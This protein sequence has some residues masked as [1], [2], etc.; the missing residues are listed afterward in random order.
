MHLRSLAMIL[1]TW[2]CGRAPHTAH[3]TLAPVQPLPPRSSWDSVLAV[4]LQHV[5]T[6]GLPDYR[7]QRQILIQSDSAFIS[8]SALPQI[9]SIDFVLLDNVQ[10]QRAANELGDLNVLTVARFNLG[11]DTAMVSAVSRWVWQQRPGRLGPMAS[12][13]ACEF[14]LRRLGGAWQVDSTIGCSITWH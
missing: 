5:V 4:V 6:H 2:T 12:M 9:D 1:V 3:L 7:P 11:G 10:V 13:S 14:R 8:Q